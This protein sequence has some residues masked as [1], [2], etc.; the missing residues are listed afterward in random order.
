MNFLNTLIRNITTI[1]VGPVAVLMAYGDW[2]GQYLYL[3][4]SERPYGFLM[5]AFSASFSLAILGIYL[6]FDKESENYSIKQ[7]LILITKV[8]FIFLLPSIIMDTYNQFSLHSKVDVEHGTRNYLVVNCIAITSGVL[9]IQIAMK[10]NVW[11]AKIFASVA[12]ILFSS[13]YYIFMLFVLM[14]ALSGKIP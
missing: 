6:A 12:Y 10:K 4:P 7:R 14:I 8:A 9:G 13:A 5:S 2:E 11:D 3:P 1:I